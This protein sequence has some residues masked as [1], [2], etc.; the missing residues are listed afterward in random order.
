VVHN[1]PH[2]L[3]EVELPGFV[4]LHSFDHAWTSPADP[5][6]PK[7]R[8]LHGQVYAVSE[9]LRDHAARHHESGRLV[10]TLLPWVDDSFNQ[11]RHTAQPSI[12]RLLFPNRISPRKGVR[13][14]LVAME[15]AEVEVDFVENIAPNE[16][17]TQVQDEL[18]RAI[19]A[20]PGA[21]LIPRTALPSDT[22]QRYHSYRAVIMPST[23]P[24]GLGMVA[25]EAAVAGVAFGAS[26]QG[27]LAQLAHRYGMVVH[28]SE[29]DRFAHELTQLAVALP[30][31]EEQRRHA[32]HTFSRPESIDRFQRALQAIG[33][34]LPQR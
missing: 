21:R 24:E 26:A 5:Y 11:P 4:V 25:A 34:D 19:E 17:P 18:L 23:A 33:L 2:W 27:G 1:R 32:A 3:E 13:E 30:P 7:D 12:D 31:S 10:N 15:L 6:P 9:A 20:T 22:A 16:R 8:R 14:T 28:P 29:P